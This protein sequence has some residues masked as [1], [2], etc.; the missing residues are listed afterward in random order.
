MARQESGRFK[1]Q[2]KDTGNSPLILYMLADPTES[3][4]IELGTQHYL[5][6]RTY[7]IRLELKGIFMKLYINDV[8]T[9]QTISI[10]SGPNVFYIGY[11][12]PLLA[13]ADV[14]ISDLVIDGIK[15]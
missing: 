11:S 15:K 3:N 6:G 2:V 12:L 14:E 5:Y 9:K 4:G 13:G 10:P 1:L 8:D 7:N